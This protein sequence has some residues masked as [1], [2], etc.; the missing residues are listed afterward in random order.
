M[1]DAAPP[2]DRLRS[3]DALRGFDMFWIVGGDALGRALAAVHELPID[4]VGELPPGADRLWGLSLPEPSH[5]LLL[6][7]SA[8]AVDLVVSG[9]LGHHLFVSLYRALGGGWSPSS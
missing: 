5:E 6:D 3:L 8:A 2:P 1:S 4:A 9:T 7:L